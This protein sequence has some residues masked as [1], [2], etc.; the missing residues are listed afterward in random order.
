MES[1]P[2]KIGPYEIQGEIGRGGTALV[3]RACDTRNGQTIALK[4]MPPEFALQAAFLLRFVKEGEN[5]IHLRHPNIVQIYEAGKADGYHYIAMEYIAG[6]TL[7]DYVRKHDTLLP[8]AESLD[9]LAQVGDALDYAHAKGFVHRDIKMSNILMGENGRIVLADFGVAKNF[10]GDH[11]VL[12]ATGYRVGTPT[13]MSPEQITGN[14]GLDQRSDVYS[15]GVMAYTLFTGRP[16]FRSDNQAELMYKVV[17]ETPPSPD[18]MNPELPP[19]IVQAINRVLAKEPGKRF[20]SVFE[21][22]TALVKPPTVL[23]FGSS[24]LLDEGG[25]S[26]KRTARLKQFARK[27]LAFAAV[28]LLLCLGWYYRSHVQS[29]ASRLYLAGVE[30]RV[31][32]V[33]EAVVNYTD[34]KQNP[35]FWEV[36]PIDWYRLNNIGREY[37]IAISSTPL[38]KLNVALSHFRFSSE[39]VSETWQ[40]LSTSE[41]DQTARAATKSVTETKT[42]PTI[43]TEGSGGE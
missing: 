11:S 8:L 36:Q 38:K 2:K 32:Q 28:A 3:Y 31:A 42:L 39:W 35:S 34:P 19:H 5:A 43:P 10:V 24:T 15:F 14:Q 23:E 37:G 22:V 12:T 40:S 41:S 27:S 18:S 33:S 1:T 29:Q 7:S 30:P 26:A 13:Y 4:V 9:I 20:N 17:H 21:F 25:V 16:P 6:G